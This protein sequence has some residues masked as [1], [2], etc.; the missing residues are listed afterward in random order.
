M[1]DMPALERVSAYAQ[2]V[3]D[4]TEIAGPHVRNACQRHF[5]DLATGHERGLWFDDEEADRVFRFF[6]ELELS[7][8]SLKASP[9]SCT[10]R[11]HSSSVRCSAGS[12]RTVPAVFVVRTSK[13]ARVTASLH[14]LAVSVYL[15]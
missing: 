4:G 14:S 10:H 7:E 6:E 9:S 1:T 13:K 3:L 8:A 11:K 2:A 5:D 12:V 15:D